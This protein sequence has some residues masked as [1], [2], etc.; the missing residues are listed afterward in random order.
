[1]KSLTIKQKKYLYWLLS[2]ASVF[3]ISM[4]V[5][6]SLGGFNDIS[7]V[8]SGNNIYNVAGKEY[9]GRITNDSLNTIFSEMKEMVI[10]KTIHGELCVINYRDGTLEEKEVHQ[11]I[12][13]LL[14]DEISEIPGGIEVRKFESV[15][16]YM[17]GLGMHP[18]VMPNS[19]KIEKLIREQAS[20]DGNVLYDYSMEILFPDNSVM[21]QMLKK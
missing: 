11:F 17:V 6:Y 9:K 20:K 12:G 13:V 10:Q 16:T 3:A 15:L 2:I 4:S 5:Y 18:L 8:T 19:Q 1:M 21:V 14:G 7:V